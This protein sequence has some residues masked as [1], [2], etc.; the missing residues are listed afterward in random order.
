M[1]GVKTENAVKVDASEP[2]RPKTDMEKLK[3]CETVRVRLPLT[4]DEEGKLVRNVVPV[5]VNGVHMQILEGMDVD[6]PVPMY[7]VLKQSGQYDI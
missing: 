3:E 2:V 5:S 1:A 4:R 6:L 7:L